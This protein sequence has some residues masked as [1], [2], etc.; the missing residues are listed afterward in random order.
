MADRGFCII[1]PLFLVKCCKKCC[2]NHVNPS[3][4]DWDI[5]ILTIS[6]TIQN[7]RIFLVGK[8]L[9]HHTMLSESHVTTTLK[10]W[11][12]ELLHEYD[13]LSTWSKKTTV[14]STT[15][16]MESAWIWI[17]SACFK[18]VGYEGKQGLRKHSLRK[19]QLCDGWC[20]APFLL[21]GHHWRDFPR[22]EAIQ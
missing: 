5:R 18:I 6:D 4:N 8:Y 15:C 14:H 20:L 10:K 12:V 16:W 2:L 13:E 22:H 7:L 19:I 21:T 9:G 3:R 1:T 17:F 11:L